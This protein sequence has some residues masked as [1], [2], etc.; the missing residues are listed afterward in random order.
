MHRA[1]SRLASLLVALGSL[2]LL[3]GCESVGSAAAGAAVGAAVVHVTGEDTV[4][5][6]LEAPYD[7]VYDA[8]EA[9]LR[10]EGGIPK[11]DRGSGH[12]EAEAGHSSVKIDVARVQK[13]NRTRLTVKARKNSGISPDAERAGQIAVDIAQRVN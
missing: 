9:E 12:L 7:R 6:Y 2:S 11:G 8:A 10:D 4:E 13:E 3:S 5:V 1:F